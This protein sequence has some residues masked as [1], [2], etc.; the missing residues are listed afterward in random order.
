[1]HGVLTCVKEDIIFLASSQ[2]LTTHF[3]NTRNFVILMNTQ[4]FPLCAC[5]VRLKVTSR[6]IKASG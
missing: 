4:Q 6:W 3:V 1:M 2:C 5:F